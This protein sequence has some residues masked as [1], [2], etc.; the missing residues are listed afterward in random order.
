MID[1]FDARVL[2]GEIYLPLERLV[3]YYGND[4]AR[5]ADAVQLCAVVD[6]VERALDREDH[7]RLRSRAA[8]GRVAELGAGQSR[9]PAGGEP[10]RAGAGAGRRD[11]AVD[12]ARNADALLWRRDRHASGRDRA[13]SGARSLREERAGHRRRP[14]RLPD[15][16]AMGCDAPM[17]ASRRRRR[18]C[19]WPTILRTKTWSIST[20]TRRSILSLY[21]A[22]IRLRKKLPALVSGELRAD[23][24]EGDLLLYRRQSE[25]AAIV[26][27]LNLGAEPVSVASSRDRPRRRNPAVDVSRP[28][29]RKIEGAL[30]L[31]G[32]EG[33]IVG[34]AADQAG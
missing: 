19:R 30:D 10:G 26:I 15:A 7:C 32:N 12:A 17:P 34:T 11:A 5:R 28:A 22:L 16:D 9:S 31:R 27:A 29:G 20:P 24:G 4:L 1:E 18:G 21:K 33:V 8:A 13:R 25:G 14:R 23:R 3:A 6:A 2:I